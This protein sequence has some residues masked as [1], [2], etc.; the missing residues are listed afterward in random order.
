[1]KLSATDAKVKKF[2]S[3][4]PL[5][6]FNPKEKLIRAEE[7]NPTHLFFLKSG[8]VRQSIVSPHGQIIS[9][10][11]FKPGSF[12]PI[13]LTM[14]HSP[15]KFIFEAVTLVEAA[16]ANYKDVE[17]FLKANPDVLYDL[18]RRLGMGLI[19]LTAS[20]ELLA[21]NN[22]KNRILSALQLLSARYGT[23]VENKWM[24]AFP[25]THTEISRLVGLARETVT[26]ELKKLAK[27]GDV[28]KYRGHLI[29]G[30]PQ[31]V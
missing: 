17:K 23:R 31:T 16:R 20:I 12:F 9:V 29:M 19:H 2:F 21:T 6:R 10:N 13:I 5:T 15:N 25:I 22:A 18:T 26:R 3:R 4:Y 1:M 27:S 28:Y 11:V 14:N 24:I 8:F 30:K 7:V